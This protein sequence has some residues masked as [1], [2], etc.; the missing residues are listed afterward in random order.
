M[1]FQR[2]EVTETAEVTINMNTRLE[3]IMSNRSI[4][5]HCFSIYKM[6]TNVLK[7]RVPIDLSITQHEIVQ[8]R[9]TQWPKIDTTRLTR[10]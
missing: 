3:E 5:L 4:Y 10:V 1:Q 9:I 6:N 2:H 8:I 7:R